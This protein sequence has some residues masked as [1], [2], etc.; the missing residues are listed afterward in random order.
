MQVELRRIQS[1]LKITT[2]SVTHDQN[3]ALTMSDR[4]AV[5]N[6]GR[7]EQFGSPK[8]IY[9]RPATAFIGNFVGR[10]NKIAGKIRT[11]TNNMVE[12]ATADG[13]SIRVATTHASPKLAKGCSAN[14][15]VRPENIELL[16]AR[17]EGKNL[18]VSVNQNQLFGRVEKIQ[19]SGSFMLV[20]VQSSEDFRLTVQL[21][22]KAGKFVPGE[23]VVVTWLIDHTLLWAKEQEI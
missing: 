17:G 5:M 13:T 12:V 19:Y 7:I 1:E 23:P 4:I 14:V 8:E 11:I 21:N 16:Q 18:R 10:I 9:E 6:E 20:H 22:P 3:E 2:L 15:A